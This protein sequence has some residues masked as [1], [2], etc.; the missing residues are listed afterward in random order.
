MPNVFQVADRIVVLRLGE[1]VAELDPKTASIEDAVAAM[2]GS[3]RF[4][5]REASQG[6]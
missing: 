4:V 6:E 2:T 5:S 1:V 3:A